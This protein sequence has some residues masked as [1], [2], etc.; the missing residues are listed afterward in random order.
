MRELEA[1][2]S[3]KAELDLQA[4]SYRVKKINWTGP[5]MYHISKY[6]QPCPRGCCFD[7]VFEAVPITERIEILVEKIRVLAYQLRRT[8][9]RIKINPIGR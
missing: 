1:N 6:S 4:Q 7:T 5:G 3:S 9:D 8:R 2:Y